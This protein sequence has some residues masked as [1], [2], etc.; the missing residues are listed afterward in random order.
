MKFYHSFKYHVV[1]VY[2]D[3]KQNYI[4][5]NDIVSTKGLISVVQ[6]KLILREKRIVD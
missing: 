6:N 3:M 2:A 1:D 4:L 5:L